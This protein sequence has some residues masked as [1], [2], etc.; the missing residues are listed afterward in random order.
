MSD[1]F[2]VVA[3]ITYYLLHPQE[4]YSLQIMHTAIG[5]RDEPQALQDPLWD[6]FLLADQ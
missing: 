4:I 1:I 5:V 2:N 3:P 6:I